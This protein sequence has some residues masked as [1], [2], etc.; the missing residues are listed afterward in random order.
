MRNFFAFAKRMTRYP[1]ALFGALVLAFFSALGVGTAMLAMVPVLQNVVL[2]ASNRDD[3]KIRDL[4][5][6]ARQFNQ[7]IA[8]RLPS[9]TAAIPET[10]IEALPR[11]AYAAAL[12]I[13]VGL[14]VLTV[15]GAAASFLHAYLSQTL[16]NRVV[17]EVRRESFRRVLKRPLRDVI[18]AGN[19]ATDLVSRVVNDTGSLGGAM[20]SLLGKGLAEAT[21]AVAAVI[22]AVIL[23]WRLA[24]VAFIAGGIIA[25]VIRLLSRRIR[26]A[27]KQ[28]LKSHSDL[29]RVS[30]EALQ[31]LRVVK[32]HTA[33]RIEEGRFHRANKQ[34]LKELNRVR[35][36]R[37]LA[38]P[39]TE[40]IAILAL[41]TLALIAIKA[42]ID[43]ALDPA[44][45]LVALAGL[46][47][48]GGAL[49]PLTGIIA[50]LQIGAAAADRLTELQAST[51]EPGHGHRLA[52]L[53]R[54]ARSIEFRGVT[55]KYAGQPKPAV[56]D[57]SLNIAHGETVA[58]VGPNGCGKTSLLSLVP[59]LY[60]PDAGMLLI[61]GNNVRDFSV[62][63][64]RRQIGVVT[65][66]T[67]M[68]SGT[69]RQNISY[70]AT[71]ASEAEILDAAR[72][73]RALEF[74]ERLPLGLDTPVA[75][76]GLSLS[77]GQRQRLAIARAIL[78]NPA[79][80]ILDEATSMIDAESEHLIGEAIS[81]FTKGRT[82]LIVAHRL[83]TVVQADRIVVMDQGKV[84]DI[85]RH[86]ELLT[87]C[88]V[89]QRLVRTQLVGSELATA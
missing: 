11:G 21:K 45:F 32:V 59:R 30:T 25:A 72:K 9:V 5:I 56:E 63:S 50:D 47:L 58:F 48:A 82:C 79:I 41:G 70:G 39:L 52:R 49:K 86:G 42:M 88:S 73:S 68:F 18:S 2:A 23:D 53:A 78:R 60:D 31:G 66:E 89:Y 55:L 26:K 61:D 57:I 54:H 16:V 3:P 7:R 24:F 38:S 46:G 83:S 12:W 36:A 75:E 51:P 69:I 4:P 87:R 29:L 62:R 65:Q 28:A 33:E 74:I 80:L 81:D 15:L 17:T 27:S 8:E 22:V 76:Q 6:L 84:V 40:A 35:T 64:L 43:N 1:A 20:N 77:G 34:M 13:F 71:E 14:G 10:V 37:A 85:G 19:G 44:N 67:V